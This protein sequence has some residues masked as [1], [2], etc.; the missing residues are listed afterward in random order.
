MGAADNTRIRRAGASLPG[1][2]GR[3]Y[4]AGSKNPRKGLRCVEPCC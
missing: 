2:L 4:T 1:G 3:N